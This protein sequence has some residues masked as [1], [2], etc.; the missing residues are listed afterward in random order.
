[1]AFTSSGK[2][3]LNARNYIVFVL[4]ACSAVASR[5]EIKKTLGQII[6][7]KSEDA[8]RA[9]WQQHFEIAKVERERKARAGERLLS[10]REEKDGETGIK[11]LLYNRA[12]I[13]ATCGEEA[14]MNKAK[15]ADFVNRS[16]ACANVK[17]LELVK[18][19]KLSEYAATI[20]A[21][22]YTACEMKSRDFNNESRFP[23]YDFLRGGSEMKLL[24]FKAFNDCLLSGQ[25]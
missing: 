1:M 2:R 10:A 20:G 18:F 22:R 13:F 16:D 11:I 9:D 19:T 8:I 3:L 24:N 23:P 14:G 5:A 25:R 17:L 12:V 15:E 6:Y 21:E 4:V 7:E